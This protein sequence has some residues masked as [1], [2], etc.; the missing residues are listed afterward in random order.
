MLQDGGFG[1]ISPEDAARYDGYF[2]LLDAGA[3]GRVGRAQAAPLFERAALPPHD[4]DRLWALANVTRDGMLS[5]S[6]FRVAMHLAT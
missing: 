1:S 4:V 6:E 5:Q 3:T 2:V